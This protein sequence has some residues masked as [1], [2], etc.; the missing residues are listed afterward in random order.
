MTVIVDVSTPELRP[1]SVVR[2]IKEHRAN[3]GSNTILFKVTAEVLELFRADSKHAFSVSQVEADEINKFVN[4]SLSPESYRLNKRF[5]CSKCKRVLTFYDVFRTGRKRHGDDHIRRFIAGTGYHVQVPKSDQ[6]L[7]AE[8]T[9][10][11]TV[12]MLED[13]CYDANNYAYA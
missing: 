9:A 6:T 2:L 12:N 4:L 10:C 1:E 3:P 5:E 13:S 8:C 7:E 11:S